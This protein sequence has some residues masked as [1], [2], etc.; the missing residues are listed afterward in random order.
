MEQRFGQDLVDVRTHI[1][2]PASESATALGAD[3]Y[4]LGQDVVFGR[5]KFDPSSRTGRKLIAHELAHTIQQRGTGAQP[6]VSTAAREHEADR[7]ASEALQGNR[8]PVLAPTGPGVA[9]QLSGD[10]PDSIVLIDAQIRLVQQQLALP[11]QPLRAA[12]LQRLQALVLRRRQLTSRSTPREPAL[13]PQPA[14][15]EEENYQAMLAYHTSTR[16]AALELNAA[17]QA[18][19]RAEVHGMSEVQIYSQW[20]TG[21]DA[22]VAVASSPAH[23]LKARPFLEIWLRH[24][25]DR[26]LAGKREVELIE[27]AEI[28]AD[29]RAFARKLSRFAD[30]ERDAL[31]PAYAQAVNDIAMAD[32]MFRQVVY[33]LE[34]LWAAET[35]GKSLTL[36]EL[37]EIAIIKDKIEYPIREGGMYLGGVPR[38]FAPRSLAPIGMP[39]PPSIPQAPVSPSPRPATI[40]GFARDIQPRPPQPAPLQQ[41]AGFGRDIQPRAPQPAP[42]QQ[43]AGFGR[44]IQ[45]QPPQTAAPP[46]PAG[47]HLGQT[48]A[49]PG[50][51]PV[52][53]AAPSTPVIS[54]ARQGQPP[55]AAQVP[56]EQASPAKPVTPA[57]TVP[58][59]PADPQ[60]VWVQLKDGRIREYRAHEVRGKPERGAEVKTPDGA[61]QVVSRG[62]PPTGGDVK[63]PNVQPGGAPSAT[64]TLIR[65]EELNKPISQGKGVTAPKRQ[66]TAEERRTANDILDALQDVNRGNAAAMDRVSRLRPHEHTSGEFAGWWSVDLLPGNPGALNVMRIFFRKGKDGLIEAIIRHYH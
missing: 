1:D 2:A 15:T 66:L 9:C 12:L 8:V 5:G 49:V 31:G 52:T 4:T 60:S 7:A 38:V 25:E 65:P 23:G 37:S 39:R 21:K 62:E 19:L 64:P 58:R 13:R 61:G 11:V 41:V 22:F 56:K 54:G 34:I 43:I 33:A 55:V 26:R 17:T 29:G 18:R 30:G 32:G 63:Q 16:Q 59:G 44:D 48:Q 53:P 20:K 24:W 57:V 47:P 50:R 40:A 3:A 51:L 6:P 35:A 27:K 42:L 28:A 45:P 10:I 46:L 36:Q 14:L